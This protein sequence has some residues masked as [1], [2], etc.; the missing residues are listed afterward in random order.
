MDVLD[1]NDHMPTLVVPS[2]VLIREDAAVGS[3]VARAT[4]ND[5][6]LNQLLTFSLSSQNGNPGQYFSIDRYE[7]SLAIFAV[8]C[9]CC[10]VVTTKRKTFF[11]DCHFVST[12][13]VIRHFVD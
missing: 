1:I 3:M 5:I 12:N 10:D 4:A 2:S 11:R 8:L 6:D 7:I 9:V 13:S